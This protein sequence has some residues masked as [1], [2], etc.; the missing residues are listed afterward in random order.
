MSTELNVENEVLNIEQYNNIDNKNNEQ[1]NIEI[2]NTPK[3]CYV[4]MEICDYK[5][6][7]ECNIHVHKKCLEKIGK[8]NCTICKKVFEEDISILHNTGNQTNNIIYTNSRERNALTRENNI[9]TLFTFKKILY[10]FLIFTCGTSLLLTFTINNKIFF[11]IAEINFVL[12]I[13][14]KRC[15]LLE[16]D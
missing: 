9:Q 10:L 11:L 4:C 15:L 12:L 1:I 3:I 7:C 2:N 6:P 8:E 14:T 13:I 5:S 16:N